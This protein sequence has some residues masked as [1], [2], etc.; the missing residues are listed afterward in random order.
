MW[1]FNLDHPDAA[2]VSSRA[3]EAM[4]RCVMNGIINGK[5]GKL[6]PKGNATRAEVATMLMRFKNLG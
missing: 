1:T 4:H 3:D 5:D 6:A 2:S